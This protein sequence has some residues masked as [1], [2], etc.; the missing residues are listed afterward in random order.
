MQ[1]VKLPMHG[2]LKHG[3]DASHGSHGTDATHHTVLFRFTQ[4]VAVASS[5]VVNVIHGVIGVR[6]ISGSSAAILRQCFP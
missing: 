5:Q 1:L 4:P 6:T 2:D 3:T